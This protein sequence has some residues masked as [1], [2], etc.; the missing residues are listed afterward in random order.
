MK[1]ILVIVAHSDDETLGM[2]ATIARHAAQGDE[3]KLMVM[4]NGI[5][6]RVDNEQPSEDFIAQVKAR[7]VAS[8]KAANILGIK[9]IFQLDFPDNKMDTMALLTVVKAIEDVLEKYPPDVVY[10]HSRCDLN[11]DHVITHKAVLTACRPQKGTSVRK[12]LSFEVLS[13]TEWNSPSQPSF[14]PQYI[15]DIDDYWHK[16]S[17][18]LQCYQAELRPYPHSRSMECIEAQATLRGATFGFNKAEAFFVERI[19]ASNSL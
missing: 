7:Q 19:L 12:I 15:I 8:E 9:E 17:Q 6:A 13:S 4:T 10:T 5:G 3:V 1:K 14:I 18:A 11:V 16:K 2:G